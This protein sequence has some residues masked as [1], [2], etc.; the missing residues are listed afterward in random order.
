[1]GTEVGARGSVWCGSRVD[2][3]QAARSSPLRA[4][5]VPDPR[6]H[7]RRGPM[8]RR[9]LLRAPRRGR[10]LS[11]RAGRP[12][13]SHTSTILREVAHENTRRPR[14]RS[15]EVANAMSDDC[16]VVEVRRAD[17]APAP[18]PASVVAPVQSCALDANGPGAARSRGP[19]AV[20]VPASPPD[21]GMRFY[22]AGCYAYF[23]SMPSSMNRSTFPGIGIPDYINYYYHGNAGSSVR[24]RPTTGWICYAYRH[25]N[26]VIHHSSASIHE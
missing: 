2:Q 26:S 18:A 20:H 15:R 12:N 8:G 11:W 1:M 17:R 5:P 19:D 23:S 25:L 4:R 10:L 16:V 24:T 14:L 9:A 22:A 13:L 21:R 7:R 3:H 6:S